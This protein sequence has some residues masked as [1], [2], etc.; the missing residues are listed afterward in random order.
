CYDFQQL[1]THALAR[2]LTQPL[3]LLRA[4]AKTR[5]MRLS[6][7]VTGM[8]AEEAQDTEVIFL[9]AL[10]RIANEANETRLNICTRAQRVMHSAI[11]VA[12]KRV[13]CEIASR[14]I[15]FPIFRKGNIGAAAIRHHIDAKRGDFEVARRGDGGDGTVLEARRHNLDAPRLQQRL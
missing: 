3:A 8:E 11:R 14:G 1:V 13:H 15:G 5:S 12:I 10:M 4:G 2:K 9:N 6:L 7:A